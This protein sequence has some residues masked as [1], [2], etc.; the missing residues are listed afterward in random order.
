MLKVFLAFTLLSL[1]CYGNTADILLNNILS[2]YT[3]KDY[4]EYK[5][6]L[7]TIELKQNYVSP[8]IYTKKFKIVSPSMAPEINTGNLVWVD[9]DF[10][11]DNIKVGDVILYRDIKPTKGTYNIVHRVI[12]KGN[13]YLICKGDRNSS[14]DSTPVTINNYMGKV[15]IVEQYASL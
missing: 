9:S 3:K 8:K 4:T 13:G 1:N 10:P 12:K 15:S 7:E 2:R 6:K 5:P 11:F 14:P